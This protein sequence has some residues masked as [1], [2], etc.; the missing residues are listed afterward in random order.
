MFSIA[1]VNTYKYIRND[2]SSYFVL[3]GAEVCPFL[4]NQKVTHDIRFGKK[5]AF[6][7]VFYETNIWFWEFIE[8]PEI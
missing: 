5:I 6:I 4:A 3:A 8:M 1:E 7:L 2:L